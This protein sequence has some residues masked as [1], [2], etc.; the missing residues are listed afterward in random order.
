M[1]KH[2]KIDKHFSSV[3]SP[4]KRGDKLSDEITNNTPKTFTKNEEAFGDIFN[5]IVSTYDMERKGVEILNKLKEKVAS[6][7]S[8]KK[9]DI[10][11]REFVGLL[12]KKEVNIVDD[13]NSKMKILMSRHVKL[14]NRADD[15]DYEE[16]LKNI[17]IEKGFDA[18]LENYHQAINDESFDKMVRNN[19]E[20]NLAVKELIRRA[21]LTELKNRELIVGDDFLDKR[22]DV[23]MKKIKF[24]EGGV[25]PNANTIITLNDLKASISEDTFSKINYCIDKQKNSEEEYIVL[26]KH[27]DKNG[28]KINDDGSLSRKDKKNFK[29][30]KFLLEVENTELILAKKIIKEFEDRGKV[31]RTIAD[32][33]YEH[34]LKGVITKEQFNYLI[35]AI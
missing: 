22:V 27:F 31:L 6:S 26:C 12:E 14:D 17:I 33:L 3:D 28:I 15:T 34:R 18:L 24:S 32:E 7:S 1:K 4:L 9:T 8:A 19:A 29:K 5:H 11:L 23:I 16:D 13:F 21:I 10:I 35:I 2:R 30:D 20:W 25:S